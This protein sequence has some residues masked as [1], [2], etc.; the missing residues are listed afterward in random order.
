MSGECV[1]CGEHC[2]DCL[3]DKPQGSPADFIGWWIDI[4]T[5]S[6]PCNGQYLVTDGV[7]VSLHT[8]FGKYKGADD[9]SSYDRCLLNV[10][11]WMLKPNVPK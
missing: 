3:C 11:H 7:I 8:Y 10:T 4:E 5:A 1:K 6:P 9:W 2:L